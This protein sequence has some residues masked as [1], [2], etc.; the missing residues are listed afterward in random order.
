MLFSSS[1]SVLQLPPGSP[2]PQSAFLN[3]ASWIIPPLVSHCGNFSSTALLPSD[4]NA[5]RHT[6]QLLCK[7]VQSGKLSPRGIF[8]PQ[9]LP[10]PSSSSKEGDEAQ[11]TTTTFCQLNN[12]VCWLRQ[13]QN[14]QPIVCLFV[15]L[16]V[17]GGEGR[18]KN[19]HKLLLSCKEDVVVVIISTALPLSQ[20]ENHQDHDG[21]SD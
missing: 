15:L 11:V 5:H 2:F 19:R 12:K 1:S 16:S 17:W 3:E 20:E 14:K 7:Q 18:H 9:H 8:C 10:P 4:D 6:Q 21:D 13:K